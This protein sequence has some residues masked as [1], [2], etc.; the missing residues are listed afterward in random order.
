M[1]GI[2][3]GLLNYIAL[4]FKFFKALLLLGGQE[5]NFLSFFL[6]I[7]SSFLVLVFAIKS[8]AALEYF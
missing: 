7:K 4:V 6:T 5:T 2:S 8:L 1:F 3:L